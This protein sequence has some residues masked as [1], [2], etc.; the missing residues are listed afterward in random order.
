MKGIFHPD[1]HYYWEE[2]PWPSPQEIRNLDPAEDRYYLEHLVQYARG[3]RQKLLMK[4]LGI[5][6]LP[7]KMENM[8][9]RSDRE[10]YFSWKSRWP[11]SPTRKS[12]KK[13]SI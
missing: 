9:D 6:E 1:R 11:G 12:S 13:R 7:E 2:E 4:K 8:G 10:E 5:S 3:A